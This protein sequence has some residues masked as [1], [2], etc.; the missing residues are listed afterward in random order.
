[1]HDKFESLI[2]Y[3]KFMLIVDIDVYEIREIKKDFIL[4]YFILLFRVSY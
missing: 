2:K 3:D 1:M 4:I